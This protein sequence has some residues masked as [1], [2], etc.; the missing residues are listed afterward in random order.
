MTGLGASAKRIVVVP[1]SNSKIRDWGLENYARLIAVL[2]EKSPCY[3]VLVGRRPNE[4]S[5]MRSSSR[6][7]GIAG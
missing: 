1:I 4:T 3:A 7:A 6:M 5:S 2:L